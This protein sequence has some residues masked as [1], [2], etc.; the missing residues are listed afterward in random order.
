MKTQTQ[1]SLCLIGHMMFYYFFTTAEEYGF[2]KKKAVLTNIM[3][4]FS[5]GSG[6]KNALGETN[7]KN[8]FALHVHVNMNI[9]T[10]R[11]VNDATVWSLKIYINNMLQYV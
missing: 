5:F 8:I 7:T 4:F 1:L 3:S 10:F 2:R 11:N 6:S 9:C